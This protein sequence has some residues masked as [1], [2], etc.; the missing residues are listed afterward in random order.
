MARKAKS[1]T[2]AIESA[3]VT[4]H[5]IV[6]RVVLAES[7]PSGRYHVRLI[8]H[9]QAGITTIHSSRAEADAKIAT[10]VSAY[11]GDGFKVSD[12]TPITS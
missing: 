12:L 1:K 4:G 11:R 7:R 3:E 2:Y 10:L 5:D 8:T 6:A 9:D